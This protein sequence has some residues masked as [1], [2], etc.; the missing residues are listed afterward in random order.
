M[1]YIIYI[2]VK[3]FKPFL[4]ILW[5]KMPYLKLLDY[6]LMLKNIQIR[7]KRLYSIEMF[8]FW[9]AC[10]LVGASSQQITSACLYFGVGSFSS[11]SWQYHTDSVSG[12]GQ[13]RWPANRAQWQDVQQITERWFWHREQVLS[14]NGKGNLFLLIPDN[15]CLTM[16]LLQDWLDIGNVT[17]VAPFLKICVCVWCFLMYSTV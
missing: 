3:Y 15:L 4:L 16:S 14:P 7:K 9:Q 1:I 8:Y 17:G 10:Y 13:E 6:F 12:S 5:D 2:R 11:S